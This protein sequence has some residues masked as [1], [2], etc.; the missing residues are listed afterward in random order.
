MRI[1]LKNFIFSAIMASLILTVGVAFSQNQ[2]TIKGVIVGRAGSNVI[3]KSDTGNVT[4]NLTNNTQ[5]E[6]VKGRFG[7]QK[8]TQAVTALIPGL[9]IEVKA[10]STGGQM[11]ADS[12]KFKADDLKTAM[13]MQ[14]A[15]TTTN[16]Q[17]QANAQGIQANAQNVQ[18]VQTEQADLNKRFSDLSDYEIKSATII[19]FGVNSSAISATGTKDLKALAASAANLKGY[20]IQVAGYTDSSGNA[21]YNQ[22]LSDERAQ[23]VIAYLQQSCGVPLFR[24][25]APAAMGMSNPA[26]SNETAQG[27]AEN[28]RVDVKVLL[29]KGLSEQ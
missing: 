9:P 14:A 23:A 13:D 27:K 8:S 3:V 29:N 28:R 17:V 16:Q 12:I 5:V 26:G 11:V 24:V 25:L 7:L 10:E 15:M 19:Y 18:Q 22:K 4:V 2:I 21:A 20:M 6:A 1:K